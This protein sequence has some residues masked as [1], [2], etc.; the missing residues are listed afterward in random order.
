MP[1]CVGIVSNTGHKTLAIHNLIVGNIYPR[2]RIYLRKI[3]C[4]L[5]SDEI[6][7][8]AKNIC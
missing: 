2:A 7:E 4:R 3:A 1:H 8:L 6:S 5:S